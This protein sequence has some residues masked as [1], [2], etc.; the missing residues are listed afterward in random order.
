MAYSI[1]SKKSKEINIYTFG[2]NP[3][4][5]KKGDKIYMI[6]KEDGAIVKD[7]F[8][9]DEKYE[10]KDRIYFED[11]KDEGVLIYNKRSKKWK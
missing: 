4:I 1:K 2:K 11:W 7:T 5:A 3:K 6:S 10:T 8:K 9:I